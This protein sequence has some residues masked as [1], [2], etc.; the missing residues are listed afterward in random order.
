[1]LH[2]IL[3]ALLGYTGDLIVDERE[4]QSSLGIASLHPDAAVS[5][6]CTFKLAPDLSSI[7]PSD[8]VVIEKIVALGFYYRELDRFATKS[9]NL[10]WIRSSNWHPLSRST[11]IA[12]VKKEETQS[13][14]RRAIANGIVEILSVYRSAVLLVE[15]N[16]LA[17]SVHVL[18]KVTH[19]LHKVC[20]PH[21]NVFVFSSLLYV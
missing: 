4:Q 8:R 21:V 10:S 20:L 3:L 18:G 5:S 1:M 16:L 15:Q 7:Q 11:E 13:L 14:Y 2:E 19:G 12:A 9:R 17:E 6:Y